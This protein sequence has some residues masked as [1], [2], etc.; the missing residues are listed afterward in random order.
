MRSAIA[1]ARRAARKLHK[2]AGTGSRQ[3]SKLNGPSFN[4]ELTRGALSAN[5]YR[6]GYSI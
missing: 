1:E 6:V 2:I 5:C 3:L 4:F